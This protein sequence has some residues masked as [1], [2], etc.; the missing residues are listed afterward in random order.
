M[1]P[2]T[3]PG[4]ATYEAGVLTPILSLQPP[5][6]SFTMMS[7]GEGFAYSLTSPPLAIQ[8]FMLKKSLPGNPGRCLPAAPAVQ[9]V[10]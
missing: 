6:L 5:F 3:K 10:A 4:M 2:G 1:V 8:F 7:L 9:V